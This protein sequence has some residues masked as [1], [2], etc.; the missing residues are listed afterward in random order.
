MSIEDK[1]R[2]IKTKEW[3]CHTRVWDQE[4]YFDAK[5]SIF[6]SQARAS[7]FSSWE[8]LVE[9][10]EEKISQ[11]DHIAIEVN[12]AWRLDRGR[13]WV[14]GRKLFGEEWNPGFW[15]TPKF[16]FPDNIEYEFA[17]TPQEELKMRFYIIDVLITSGE[18]PV[19]SSFQIFLANPEGSLIQC[20]WFAQKV[21]VPIAVQKKS[22]IN[23]RRLREIPVVHVEGAYPDHW[24]INLSLKPDHRTALMKIIAAD[25]KNENPVKNISDPYILSDDGTKVIHLSKYDGYQNAPIWKGEIELNSDF[26]TVEA[27]NRKEGMYGKSNPLDRTF[28]KEEGKQVYFGDLHG[29]T[30]SSAGIGTM[31][32]YFDWAKYGSLLDFVAPANHYGGRKIFTDALWQ[33]TITL[34]EEFN[35]PDDF[36]TLFSYEWGMADG[37]NHRNV[38]YEE[39]AGKLFDAHAPEYNN[40]YKL[41]EIL[42]KQGIKAL[43]IPHHTK[44]ISRINW[45][46]FH[47]KYQRLVEVCS[48]WGNSEQY[49]AHSVQKALEI[50]HRLGV[51]GGTDTHFSQPGTSS[52]YP[53]G[54]GGFTGV[55]CDELSRKSVWQA[56]YNRNCYATTG[57][58]ILLDFRINN[59]LMGSEIESLGQREV[60]GK[61]LGSAELEEIEIIRNNKILK[62]IDLSGEQKSEFSFTDQEKFDE[63]ALQP[64]VSVKKRFIFYY[65]RVRQKDGHWAM[66]S[67]IWIIS[68]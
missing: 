25:N 28:Y 31:R 29:Q 22:D 30:V 27:L 12:V 66:S 50:G 32:E 40:I 9:L 18:I 45:E 6:P 57:A 7:E 34:C 48:C 3:Y 63:L 56:L 23:Y 60:M 4:N 42:E 13:P 14:V 49:G 5:A 65:L 53:F 16:V 58:R 59:C 17:I 20:P 24:K 68:S 35:Q 67:P 36:I 44:F 2:R 41:W 19:H 62:S 8:I 61:V 64:S 39:T 43:T 26:C 38:Y 37:P 55:I 15:A 33:E 52:F 46:E 1:A 47:S 11:G 10:G 51:V 21:P 54:F